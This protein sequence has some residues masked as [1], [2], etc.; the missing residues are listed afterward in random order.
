[1]APP[2]TCTDL[3]VVLQ[4]V[5]NWKQTTMRRFAYSVLIPLL[6]TPF[7]GA[8]PGM[9]R[10]HIDTDEA[11]A[12]GLLDATSTSLY[13]QEQSG[14]LVY[15]GGGPLH[16]SNTPSRVSLREVE[17]KRAQPPQAKL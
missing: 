12:V 4:G 17:A 6:V 13:R 7:T 16:P 2:C 15:V 10:M 5:R 14:A 1:M 8:D 9:T 3:S 11:N